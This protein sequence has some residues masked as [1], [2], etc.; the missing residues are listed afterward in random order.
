MINILHIEAWQRQCIR[1]TLIE[2]HNAGTR[3][4]CWR[5][6]RIYNVR[7]DGPGGY[8]FSRACKYDCL[9]QAAQVLVN[10]SKPN[11]QNIRRTSKLVKLQCPCCKRVAQY[12]GPF[13]KCPACALPLDI[14]KDRIR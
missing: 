6:G 13:P 10:R 3:I 5:N 2:A 4:D 1:Q 9:A 12:A 7:L 14:E 8:V 11:I